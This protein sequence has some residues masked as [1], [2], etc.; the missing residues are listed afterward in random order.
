MAASFDFHNRASGAGAFGRSAGLGVNQVPGDTGD[1]HIAAGEGRS[2][3][4]DQ[5]M[6][7]TS[8]GL[9]SAGLNVTNW[10]RPPHSCS[11]A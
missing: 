3:A 7:P 6:N 11:T 10:G 2:I 1:D 9:R 4:F 8:T 5:I